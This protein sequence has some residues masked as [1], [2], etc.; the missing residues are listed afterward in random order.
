MQGFGDFM[1]MVSEWMVCVIPRMSSHLAWRNT[2]A[3]VDIM[4]EGERVFKV[5]D[6]ISL[7]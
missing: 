7:P 4:E 1:N 2:S 3:Q 6:Y 5:Q